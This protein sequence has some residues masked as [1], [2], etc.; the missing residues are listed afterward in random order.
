MMINYEAGD[1]VVI[2]QRVCGT[3]DTYKCRYIHE[4]QLTLDNDIVYKNGFLN[5]EF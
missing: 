1:K 4:K 3:L 5:K 2:I